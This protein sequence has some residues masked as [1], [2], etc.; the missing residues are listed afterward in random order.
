MA[1]VARI[2]V[3][4]LKG[5][6]LL[7][8]ASVELTPLGIPGNRRFHLV[9]ER[10]ELFSCGD[11]GPLMRVGAAYDAATEMLVLELPGGT[12]VEAGPG[13]LGG[14]HVTDFY[15]TRARPLRGGRLRRDLQPRRASAALFAPM[16]TAMAP[17]SPP[18][19]VSLGPWRTWAC[20][21]D[22]R[23]LLPAGSA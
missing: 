1:T 22:V 7:N 15:A 5:T 11:F 2:C 4:P 20:A 12:R 13:D 9:N 6:R 16:R 23:I 14:A 10:G 19:L 17:T 3:T 8:P 18:L 21:T